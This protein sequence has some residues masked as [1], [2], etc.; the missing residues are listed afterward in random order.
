MKRALQRLAVWFW[1]GMSGVHLLGQTTNAVALAAPKAEIGFSLLRLGGAFALVLALFFG[2][3]WCFRNGQR[4]ALYRGRVPKLD[5]LEVK[6]LGARQALYVVGYEQQR[7][8]LAS[9]PQGI[10]LVS[11]LP[12]A[13][14]HEPAPAV[15]SFSAAMQQALGQKS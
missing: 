6:S 7:L 4:M 11:H 14:G 2:G 5:V 12:A 3:V 8:L 1:L 10:T 9:S 13:A 15:I